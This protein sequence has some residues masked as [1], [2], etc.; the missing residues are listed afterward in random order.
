MSEETAASNHSPEEVAEVISELEKYRHRL[1]E[2]FTTTAK[3][4]KLPKSLVM[5]QLEN[6]P[7]I[8]K[9]DAS[10]AQLRGE[11]PTNSEGAKSETTE[12]ENTATS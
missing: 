6:H 10:L 12:P 11:T 3:K 5:A 2:D 8:A 4:A 1:V 9:I 7:E